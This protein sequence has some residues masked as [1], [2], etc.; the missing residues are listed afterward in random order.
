MRKRI[1]IIG[2]DGSGIDM[3]LSVSRPLFYVA[4][5]FRS[6]YRAVFS[7][8]S[9][10]R[11]LTRAMSTQLSLPILHPHLPPSTYLPKSPFTSPIRA[12]RFSYYSLPFQPTFI[13]NSTNQQIPTIRHSIPIT[14]SSPLTQLPWIEN[15]QSTP[16]PLWTD[17]PQNY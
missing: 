5:H 2:A 12:A 14:N 3:L 15:Q 9:M 7:P 8:R 16:T 17:T 11:N 4:Y 10:N 13:L 6:S 1:F